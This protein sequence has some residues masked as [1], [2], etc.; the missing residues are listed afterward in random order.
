MFEAKTVHMAIPVLLNN[1]TISMEF[2]Y[3]IV[4]VLKNI[5]Y[6]SHM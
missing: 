1:I 6:A 3:N 4:G 5:T 2:L